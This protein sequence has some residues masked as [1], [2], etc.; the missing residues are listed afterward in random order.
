MIAFPVLDER[1]DEVYHRAQRKT[2]R[3]VSVD[4]KAGAEARIERGVGAEDVR[5]DRLEGK[6]ACRKGNRR[7]KELRRCDRRRR[8]HEERLS[9]S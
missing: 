5:E 7:S 1:A 9:W 4:G 8:A 2:K 3:M 6:N